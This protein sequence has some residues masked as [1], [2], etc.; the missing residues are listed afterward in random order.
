MPTGQA[1]TC[2]GADN[3]SA[4]GG[5]KIA[6]A[7][8]AFAVVGYQLAAAHLNSGIWTLISYLTLGL[9]GL[10]LLNV[11]LINLL[12]FS[13][14][15]QRLGAAT[16]LNTVFRNLGSAI[17]P[18]VAGTIL[19]N[20]STYAYFNTP[21]GPVYFSVPSRDAYVINIDIATAMF[22]SALAPILIAKE[23]LGRDITH[24]K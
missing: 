11:S 19:T 7:G 9:V 20:Y 5:K 21:N 14:P 6:V 18:T 8:V 13:V 4:A 23:V 2:G 1:I 17:A 12:T 24:N 22:I 16:G 15:R 10:T 3:C